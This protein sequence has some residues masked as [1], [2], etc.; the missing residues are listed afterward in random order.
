MM[1][2]VKTSIGERQGLFE[3]YLVEV[4]GSRSFSFDINNNGKLNLALSGDGTGLQWLAS[5]NTI[6]DDT[7]T[8][9]AAISDGTTMKVYIIGVLDSEIAT[10]HYLFFACCRSSPWHVGFV[11]N[12]S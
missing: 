5:A 10:T 4:P 6:T 11:I 3:R 1:T 8:H 12:L 9:V 7:W 2:Y